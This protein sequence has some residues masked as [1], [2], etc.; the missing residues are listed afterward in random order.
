MEKRTISNQQKGLGGFVRQH[1]GLV[2]N[3]LSKPSKELEPR[4]KGAEVYHSVCPYCAVGCSHY[5]SGRV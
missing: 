2:P 4:T 1:I 3:P 5:P